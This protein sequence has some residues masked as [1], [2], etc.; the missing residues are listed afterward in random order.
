MFYLLLYKKIKGQRLARNNFL[1]VYRAGFKWFSGMGNGSNNVSLPK[2]PIY[3]LFVM[4][5]DNDL[6]ITFFR[7]RELPFY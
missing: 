6:N 4:K 1:L 3:S 2:L 7:L 5:Y